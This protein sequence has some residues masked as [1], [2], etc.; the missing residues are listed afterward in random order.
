MVVICFFRPVNNEQKGAV[1]QGQSGYHKG[2]FTSCVLLELASWAIKEHEEGR[3]D[4]IVTK[5][6]RGLPGGA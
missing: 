5:G 2:H 6:G 3:T 4:K 1:N